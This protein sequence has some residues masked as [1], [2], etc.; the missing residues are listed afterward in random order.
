MI[1]HQL[2]LL[3]LRGTSQ[4]ADRRRLRQYRS[5]LLT[6]ASQELPL[7]LVPCNTLNED[8]PYFPR[9]RLLVRAPT[10]EVSFDPVYVFPLSLA[11]RSRFVFC[12]PPAND[13]PEVKTK[14]SI[15]MISFFIFSTPVSNYGFVKNSSLCRSLPNT[16]PCYNYDKELMKKQWGKRR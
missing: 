13:N 6:N 12:P 2:R 9:A 16:W 14:N 4:Q 8:R 3:H 5:Y 7:T 10:S 1:P 15:A 11:P